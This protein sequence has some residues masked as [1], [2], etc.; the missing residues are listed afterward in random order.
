MKEKM[1]RPSLKV[2]NQFFINPFYPLTHFHSTWLLILRSSNEPFE[3]TFLNKKIAILKFRIE[4]V[5]IP[6]TRVLGDTFCII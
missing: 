3:L 2:T 1:G 5:Q 4:L 6:F